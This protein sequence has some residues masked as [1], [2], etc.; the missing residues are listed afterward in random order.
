MTRTM[1]SGFAVA[2][3]LFAGGAAPAASQAFKSNK[4]GQRSINL[5]FEKFRTTYPELQRKAPRAGR[6]DARSSTTAGGV[7]KLTGNKRPPAQKEQGIIIY[8]IQG[9]DAGL[10]APPKKSGTSK[11]DTSKDDCMSCD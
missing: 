1:L 3:M 5:N 7:G 11:P 8:D 10:Y 2:A 6:S 9:G 4:A